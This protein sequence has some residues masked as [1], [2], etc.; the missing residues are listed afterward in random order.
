L[1]PETLEAAAAMLADDARETLAAG[2]VFATTRRGWGE[3]SASFVEAAVHDTGL[4]GQLR[5]GK[6]AGRLVAVEEAGPDLIAVRGFQNKR[7]ADQ[8]VQK[9]LDQYDRL[10]DG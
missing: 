1:V 4:A 7:A 6:L 9:R 10:W 8:F 5:I 2:R 3:L